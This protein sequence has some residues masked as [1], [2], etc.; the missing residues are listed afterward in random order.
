VK[1]PFQLS[2]GWRLRTPVLFS[3]FYFQTIFSVSIMQA[4]TIG[5]IL[6]V[7]GIIMLAYT[8]FNYV[9]TETLVDIGPIQIEA[10]KN[11]FVKLSPIIGGVLLIGGIFLLFRADKALS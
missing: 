10:E 6:I 4:K 9:T 1:F 3:S 11:N 7:I 2:G 5:V 8:G